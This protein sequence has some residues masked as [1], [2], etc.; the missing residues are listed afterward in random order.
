MPRCGRDWNRF[1][2]ARS[3]LAS[4]Q[5]FAAYAASEGRLE[6]AARLLGEARREGDEIG[7]PEG[8]FAHDMVAWAK[9]RARGALGDDA[10]EAAYAAGRENAA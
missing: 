7:A 5:R 10:F 6:D 2:I 9:G 1:W 3:S 4:F 8:D